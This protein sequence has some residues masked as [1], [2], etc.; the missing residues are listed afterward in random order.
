MFIWENVL[1]DFGPPYVVIQGENA[2]CITPELVQLDAENHIWVGW[3]PSGFMDEANYSRFRS[4][5]IT[6]RDEKIGVDVPVIDIIDSHFSHLALGQLFQ[7]ALRNVGIVTGPSSLT[8]S[9][10]AN[11][12]VTNKLFHIQ[13]RELV[14]QYVQTK[15]VQDLSHFFTYFTDSKSE[16][17]QQQQPS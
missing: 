6:W 8:S 5:F 4:K 13:V 7:S 12:R 9:W 1:G 16:M 17:L 10:Q 11:D 2:S 15:F 14:E 3:S